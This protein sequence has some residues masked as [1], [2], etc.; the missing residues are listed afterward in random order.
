MFPPIA[1]KGF[2]RG[3]GYINKHTSKSASETSKTSSPSG[4]SDLTVG[5]ASILPRAE[6]G[7]TAEFTASIANY[8]I[9]MTP[10]QFQSSLVR[11][12]IVSPSGKLKSKYKR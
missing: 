4:T 8:V 1:P 2:G 12:G 11:S 5:T 6:G 3:A 7:T 9:G 10:E